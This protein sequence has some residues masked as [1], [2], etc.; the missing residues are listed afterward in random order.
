MGE[1]TIDALFSYSNSQAQYVAENEEALK[2]FLTTAANCRHYTVAN[3]LLINGYAT[4]MG[5]E[6]KDVRPLSAWEEYGITIRQGQYPIYVMEHA[7]GTEKTYIPREV[8]DISQTDA[9]QTEVTAD[10][11]LLTEAL[12][13]AA[14]C[15]L[16]YQDTMKVR[17]TRAFYFPDE[18][19][20]QTTK[21]FR[22]Y[23]EIFASVS[24][25]YVH[26]FIHNEIM[27]HDKNKTGGQAKTVYPRAVYTD[28]TLASAYIICT[29][30]KMD[31]SGFLMN[32][33]FA[34]LK[35]GNPK[36][37][38]KALEQAVVPAYAVMDKIS[39]QEQ[40]LSR[41][42]EMGNDYARG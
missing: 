8:F 14:P 32:N 31:T 36:E 4:V 18:A 33:A 19:V 29:A 27:K 11:G 16:E 17:G 10:K 30:F 38:K 5:F 6:A 26:Y 41:W 42:N 9:L 35:E 34:K 12:I 13:L 21:G 37:I 24:R 23:D 3:Q 22:S 2:A 15:P 40:R 7:P 39:E 20:I 28:T 1:V 25:E